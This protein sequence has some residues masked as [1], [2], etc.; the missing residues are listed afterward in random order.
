MLRAQ[1][2]AA[3]FLAVLEEYRSAP[4]V[5]R[6]RL[7]LETMEAILPKAEKYVI[8]LAPERTCCPCCPLRAHPSEGAAAQG[9][10]AR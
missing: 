9:G 3:R 1:G 10:D 8:T 7:Y 4:E 5:T 2:E 6:D